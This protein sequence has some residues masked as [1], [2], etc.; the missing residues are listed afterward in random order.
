VATGWLSVED[1]PF[2]NYGTARRR[3]KSVLLDK[4][5][6]TEWLEFVPEPDGLLSRVRPPAPR[7]DELSRSDN[8]A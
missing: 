7:C 1:A 2:R 6:L 4:A 3:A 5:D 8:T